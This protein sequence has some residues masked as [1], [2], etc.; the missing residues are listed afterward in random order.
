MYIVQKCIASDM[1]T[2]HFFKIYYLDQVL[3]DLTK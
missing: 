1:F 3:N 2:F